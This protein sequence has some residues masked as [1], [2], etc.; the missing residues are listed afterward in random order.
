MLGATGAGKSLL[1]RSLALID[2]LDAGE[3]RWHGETIRASQVPIFRSKVVYLHQTP[4]LFEGTVEDNLRLPFSLKVHADASYDRGAVLSLLG[5][6]GCEESLLAR[7]HEILSGGERLLV[8]LV[9]ALQLD[10]TV[11]L[12]DEPT[13][14][15]D[16]DTATHV[17]SLLNR[18]SDDK[19][20]ERATVW[21]TH[22]HAQARRVAHQVLEFRDGTV[23]RSI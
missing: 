22:D 3:L 14:A 8:A 12:L 17:E 9:R 5:S 18:W 7:S 2:G 21:V 11:L 20:T 13:A 16:R 23:Q 19:P 6:L 1:L 15:L 10:P 4:T